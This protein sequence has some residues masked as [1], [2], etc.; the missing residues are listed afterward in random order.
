MITQLTTPP[1]TG[2]SVDSFAQFWAHPDPSLVRHAVHADVVGYWP[3]T[4]EPVVGLVA[5]ADRIAKVIARIPDLRLEVLDHATNGDL[6]FVRWL[7]RGTGAHGSFE[8][9]GIDRIRIRDG[10]VAENIIV[11]DTA[12]FEQRVGDRLPYI[13][14]DRSAHG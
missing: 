11:F 3:G 13:G 9:S 7:A 14:G 4:A 5:Y 12:L 6:L 1:Q 8:L 10:L 2:F